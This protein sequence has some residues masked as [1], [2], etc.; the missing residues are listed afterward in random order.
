MIAAFKN[1][2]VNWWKIIFV[3]F[4]AAYA[5]IMLI[6]PNLGPTDDYNLL[7]TLQV[8][9]LIPFYSSLFP[10]GDFAKIGRLSILT[11]ME[12]YFFGL[13]FKSPSAF[14]Y[15][16]FHAFQYVVLMILFVKIISKFTSNKFLIYLTPILLSLTPAM[17]IPFF[18][19]F[20]NERNLIYY[21]AVFLFCY[22]LYLQKPKLGYLL[23]GLTSANLAIYYKENAF[24]ALAAFA[25]CHLLLSSKKSGSKTNEPPGQKPILKI[26]DGLVILS[27]FVYLLLYYFIV[28]RHLNP[29]IHL[30]TYTPFNYLL[31]FIK[32]LFN[33]GFF[34][35]PI[36]ILILLPFT[37][38]RIY[39]FLRRQL[40]LHPIY[41]SMLIAGSMFVLGYF[42]LNIYS[43]NYLL[44]AYIFA[45]PPL[46]YFFSQREQRTLL[47]KGVAIACGVVLI[48][49]VFPTGIHYLTYYKYLSVNF[50]KT[51]DFLISDINS[52]Y[53]SQRANIFIDAVDPQSGAAVY[54]IFTNFLQYRGLSWE[55]FNFKSSLKTGD[56]FR[57][58]IQG[59]HPPFTV[60][61]NNDAYK[62]QSGD[63]LIVPSE[64]TTKNITSDYLQSLTKDYKL[65]SKT[66]S[67]LAFPNIN[68]KT[69]AKYFLSETLSENQKMK[70]G[71]M[72]NEN[73][74]QWPNYYVFIK[75]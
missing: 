58:K 30:Y 34:T 19:T 63:Y 66:S 75:R 73:L 44:P 33:Y 60:F 28:Y 8:N 54:F 26:F 20:L 5:L 29:N 16:L 68:L 14:W 43:P 57:I 59:S 62:I 1:K 15:F 35:D 11:P 38:W 39:K 53:P 51:L 70:Q 2:K 72:I 64:A 18:R 24:I 74:M 47:F 42:V 48:F 65:L 4:V 3:V 61:Q 69:L 9:R 56:A 46:I 22:L 27:S 50:N 25:F 7:P 32:N 52:R 13:F 12:Y 23:L 67:L 49:N 45:L 10:Y 17:T 31:V 37:G 40:E 71:L 21:Y 36:L 41:D 55:R 6:K